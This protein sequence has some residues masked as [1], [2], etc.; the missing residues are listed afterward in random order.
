MRLTVAKVVPADSLGE[1][2]LEAQQGEVAAVFVPLARL[3]QDLE[4]PGRVNTLLVSTGLSPPADAAGALRALVRRNA[5]LEDLGYSVETLEPTGVLSV[6]SAAGLLDEAHAKAATSALQGTGMQASALFTYLANS[7]RVGD[8]EVP[9]SLVTALDLSAIQQ[10]PQPAQSNDSRDSIV[11]NDW[12]ATELKARAGDTVT[13]EYYAWEEPGRLVTKTTTLNVAGVVPIERGDRE[14]A[15]TYPGITRF[16]DAG[17]LGS[18]V[19]G[20]PAPGPQSRR[21]VLG[22]VSNDTEGVRR[23]WRRDSS[24][25]RRDT[26]D[27]RDS[28]PAGAR[29]NR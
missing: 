9:Y 14:M 10:P 4:I 21:G 19:P 25:G 18:A 11:L 22:E 7:L 5:Q 28:C 20:G 12:A 26:V 27:D 16:A 6:G 1:F 13:M 2:S 3:Q 17:R 24:C 23:R 8:R 15:P 29:A